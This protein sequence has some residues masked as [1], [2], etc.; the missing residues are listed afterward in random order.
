MKKKTLLSKNS[1][2]QKYLTTFHAIK[3]Y[4]FINK[5]VTGRRKEYYFKTNRKI[6]TALR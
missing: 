3:N 1:K 4:V 6:L 2:E 5:M